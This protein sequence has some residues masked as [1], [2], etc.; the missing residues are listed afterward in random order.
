[1]VV[2]SDREPIGVLGMQ[3]ELSS[4]IA[5]QVR[6]RLAP[7]RLNGLG[8]RQTRN[9]DAY[10][11][12]LRGRY[13][14]DQRVPETNARAVQYYERAIALDPDYALAWSGI[15]DTYAASAINGD[16]PPLTVGPRARDAATRAFQ[17][18]PE[19]AE[20]QAARGYVSFSLTGIGRVQRWRCDGRLSSILTTLWLTAR[21]ATFFRRWVATR[22][23]APR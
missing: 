22:R 6:L 19:L 4:A 13:F 10:D 9:A 14:E 20:V 11:L 7:E 17:A 8:R 3:R 15:A 16:A 12:Y 1:M 21:S 2:L 23:H 18:A 5:E